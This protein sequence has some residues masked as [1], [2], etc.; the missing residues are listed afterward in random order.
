MALDA[1]LAV[2]VVGVVGIAVTL[3]LAALVAWLKGRWQ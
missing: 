3:D 1:L 2:I